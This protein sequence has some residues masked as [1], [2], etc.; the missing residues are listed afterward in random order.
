MRTLIKSGRHP[1]VCSLL[2]F[3]LLGGAFFLSF[4]QTVQWPIADVPHNDTYVVGTYYDFR[5]RLEGQPD[6]EVGSF[7]HAVD[8]RATHGT[9]TPVIAVAPGKVRFR[10]MN[11]GE[12]EQAQEEY[13]GRVKNEPKTYQHRI[14]VCDP[15]DE[16]KIW[17]YLHVTRHYHSD[18]PQNPW[19]PGEDIATGDTLGLIAAPTGRGGFGDEELAHVHLSRRRYASSVSFAEADAI[20]IQNPLELLDVYLGSGLD[21]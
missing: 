15:T 1:S 14:D 20:G 6:G 16:T 17:A 4:G 9:Q 19:I 21:I 13:R 10:V 3:V 18:D 2:L 5:D 7:H 8:I 12:A 11:F